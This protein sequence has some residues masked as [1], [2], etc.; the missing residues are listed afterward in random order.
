MDKPRQ[1]NNKVSTC[2]GIDTDNKAKKH[3]LEAEKRLKKVE[4][5]YIHASQKYTEATLQRWNLRC[6]RERAINLCCSAE[7]FKNYCNQLVEKL[8]KILDK[9]PTSETKEVIDHGVQSSIFSDFRKI[10]GEARYYQRKLPRINSRK[11]VNDLRKEVRK[12][13]TCRD[14]A[15]SNFAS[16]CN[17]TS[18][19]SLRK[20]VEQEIVVVKK[21]IREIQKDFE[22][23]LHIEQYA[24][25]VYECIE[26][27]VKH[28]EV[29]KEHLSGQR[30]IL[31]LNI[32]KRNTIVTDLPPKRGKKHILML[33]I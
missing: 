11:A 14:K 2:L 17:P 15:V 21:L 31:R 30:D 26:R 22:E 25:N 19:D 10:N 16:V 18:H 6:E 7:N 3:D 29:K 9:L 12:K 28:L 27:K 1:R 13:K 5:D 32:S 24:I 4:K 20:S 8:Q 33:N 23:K